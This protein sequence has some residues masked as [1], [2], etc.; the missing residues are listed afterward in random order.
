MKMNLIIVS[1]LLAF[2][3]QLMA[4]EAMPGTVSESVLTVH[5]TNGTQG[6][7][8]AEGTPVTVTFY[9]DRQQV[10]KTI[11][12]TDSKG[13]CV[14]S[15]IPAGSGIVAVAQAKHSDMLFSSSPL[16]L[17]ADQNS[18]EMT[19]Q[20]FD[21]VNDNSLIGVGTHHLIIKKH[22]DQI[23]VTE[24]IQLMNDQDKAI[25]SDQADAESRPK[26]V[27]VNLPK[28]FENLT[29]SNY[30]NPQAVV[31]SESG[32]YDTMAIPPGQF[33]G[34]FSYDLSAED[35]VIDFT[36]E[37]T[38]SPESVM[39]FIQSEG[40]VVTG[41]GE[42]GGQMTLTDGALVNYYTV[43]VSQDPVL[44]FQIEVMT[45]ESPEQKTWMVLGFVFGAMVLV[46]LLRL[47]RR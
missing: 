3:G 21:V 9:Q 1:I 25:L 32:F 30:F 46:V 43:D 27:Q 37:I 11:A 2:A 7:S 22:A 41:L 6:S 16:Q 36:R 14:I 23:R 31:V 45:K 5:V 4:A 28:G 13:N 18:F 33:H 29:F 12:A 10:K 8:V 42:P 26:V 40:L 24:Y 19:M 38:L 35:D 34:V 15:P 39:I 44:K 17:A 20:V 47:I